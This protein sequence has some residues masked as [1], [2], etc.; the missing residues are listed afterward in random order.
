M[1]LAEIENW[2]C[3]VAGT[4]VIKTQKFIFVRP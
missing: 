2:D 4:N 1:R 3:I